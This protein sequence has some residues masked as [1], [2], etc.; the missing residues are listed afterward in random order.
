[1]QKTALLTLGRLP[2]A[3]DVATALHGAGWRVIVAEPAKWHLSRVSRSVAASFTLTAPN[4][5]RAA[6]LDD[7]LD[8]I[9]RENVSLVVPVSE[10][11][12][13]ATLVMPRLPQGV[14]FF[15]LPHDAIARLHD[16]LA[17]ARMAETF[18]L[19]VPQ[20]H[21]LGTPE[22]ERLA[23]ASDHIIKPVSTCSG[24]GLEICKAGDP[25]PDAAARPVSVVQTFL[26]GA[27]KSTFSIAHEG[28]VIGTI[29]YRAAILS[30]TV[31]V[32]F[33]R[34]DGELE[35]EGWVETFVAKA[36]HSGFIA[37]DLIDDSEGVPHAIECNPR[38]TSGVHFVE[39]ADLAGAVLDPAS[40]TAL[41]AKPHRTMQQFYPSLTE[42]QTA[43][44][45]RDDFRRKLRVLATAKEAN[46]AWRDPLPLWL[47]PFTSWGIM[48]RAFV[49]GESFGEASTHDIGWY[50]EPPQPGEIG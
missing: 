27:H 5:D 21:H 34:L 32:A 37:F 24:Q 14:R 41:R 13:H 39:P 42:T 10:E 31:A 44:F 22:A 30:G 43:A 1:M 2:K 38:I 9:A 4:D 29:V 36:N 26:G 49:N 15:S 48:K 8:I 11:A 23:A 19:A 35:I 46:F 40:Q 18:G 50:E 17:F 7:L 3:L 25:L 6:Y 20:T 28:R 12:M 33:E 47:M 16:K 45:R